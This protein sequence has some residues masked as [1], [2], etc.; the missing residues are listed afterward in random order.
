MFTRVRVTGWTPRLEQGLARVQATYDIA[1]TTA[2]IARSIFQ[3]L[4]MSVS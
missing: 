3:E 1:E 2:C 4:D